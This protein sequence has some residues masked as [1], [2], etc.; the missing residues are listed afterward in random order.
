MGSRTVGISTIIGS[1]TKVQTQMI[2]TLSLHQHGGLMKK[3][4]IPDHIF[5][6][7]SN[8]SLLEAATFQDL[9]HKVQ[10]FDCRE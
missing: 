8:P 4:Y 2:K 10:S 7:I 3:V 5:K 9:H 1:S 6:F